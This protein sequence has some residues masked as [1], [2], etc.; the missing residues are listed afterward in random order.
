M[1]YLCNY[2]WSGRSDEGRQDFLTTFHAGLDSM[3]QIW[4]Q[5]QIC[6]DELSRFWFQCY[7]TIF[8]Q[9][10]ILS[11]K[12]HHLKP[13]RMLSWAFSHAYNSNSN[14]LR[15]DSLTVHVHLQL[16]SSNFP[17]QAST[18]WH[19]LFWIDSSGIFRLTKILEWPMICYD[20]LRCGDDEF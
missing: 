1:I 17:F 13:W 7:F 12:T 18:C 9:I 8:A 4:R 20:V 6:A 11:S 14:L 16:D 15:D 19:S 2:K 5:T 3:C 10:T